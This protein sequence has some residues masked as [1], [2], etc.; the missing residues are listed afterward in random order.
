MNRIIKF[1]AWDGKRMYNVDL[2]GLTEK[3][4]GDGHSNWVSIPFQPHI[5][6]MQYTGKEDKNGV[7]IYEGEILHFIG[8]VYD[9]IY[10]NPTHRSVDLILPVDFS[11]NNGFQMNDQGFCHY[12][13]YSHEVEIIGNIYENP[14]LIKQDGQ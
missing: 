14:E 7:E 6:L 4:V 3:A 10:H 5:I 11:D 2:L 8:V 12:E 9:G 1:R 13:I